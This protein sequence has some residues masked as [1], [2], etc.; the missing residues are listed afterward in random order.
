MGAAGLTLGIQYGAGRQGVAL[1]VVHF[2]L[3]QCSGCTVTTNVDHMAVKQLINK[4]GS[5]VHH[6]L[7][8]TIL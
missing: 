6:Q 4:I 8:A 7:L 3:L 2:R 1:R 5:P